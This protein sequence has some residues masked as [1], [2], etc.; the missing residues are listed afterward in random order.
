M[1]KVVI[2]V[3]QEE[4]PS[5]ELG[6]DVVFYADFYQG[7]RQAFPEKVTDSNAVGMEHTS[8]RGFAGKLVEKREEIG[9]TIERADRVTTIPAPYT[10]ESLV[11]S[12]MPGK[13]TRIRRP[14]TA[15]EIVDFRDYYFNCLGEEADNR[16]KHH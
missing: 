13:K 7:L 15:E 8:P 16:E 5:N 12:R 3:E 2:S 6:L 14:L 11:E 9:I 10:V 1:R 4:H